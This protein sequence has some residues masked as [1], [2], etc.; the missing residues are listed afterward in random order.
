MIDRRSALA[1]TALLAFAAP[2][3]AGDRKEASI[4]M[5]KANAHLA[6]HEY[7]E[8]IARYN[9]ARKLVPASSGPYLGLGLAY[10]ATDRCREALAYLEEYLQRQ[11]SPKPEAASAIAQCRPKMVQP[12]RLKVNTDPPGAEVRIDDETGPALGVT[13]FDKA[14]LPK[15]LHRVYLSHAGFRSHTADVTVEPGVMSMISAALEANSALPLPPPPDSDRPPDPVKPPDAVTNGTKVPDGAKPVDGTRT[16]GLD[17]ARPPEID[18]A[19]PSVTE[20]PKNPPP[21]APSG[22]G[23]S[24]TSVSVR[25]VDGE[26]DLSAGDPLATIFINND[27]V[28]ADGH[29]RLRLPPGLYGVRMERD[30]YRGSEGAVNLIAGDRKAYLGEV[31]PITTHGWLSLGVGFTLLAAGAEA[32]ALAGHFVANDRFQG[33]DDFNLYSKLEFYGQIGAG[34]FAAV[35]LLGYIM[36]VV[37]NRGHVSEGRPFRILP[38]KWQEAAK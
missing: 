35:A 38:T 21:R 15:G 12:G 13:P 22:T 14:D 18:H 34:V 7:E 17:P 27:T 5:E 26:L 28:T 16:A 9:V 36:E 19:K 2:V 32:A 25:V 24:P 8:A 31:R 6:R 29:A 33:T 1:L 30:G 11:K 10:A 3:L 4:E 20:P 23:G 37:V